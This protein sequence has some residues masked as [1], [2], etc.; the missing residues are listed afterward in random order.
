MGRMRKTSTATSEI[1]IEMLFD[2]VTLS[3]VQHLIN[4]LRNAGRRQARMLGVTPDDIVKYKL[5]THPLKDVDIQRAKDALKND[6]FFQTHKIWVAAMEKLLKMGVRAE[7][8]SPEDTRQTPGQSI[9]PRRICRH[10]HAVD[11]HGIGDDPLP[12]LQ[13][14]RQSSGDADTDDATCPGGQPVKRRFQAKMI[15]A[16]DNDLDVAAGDDASFTLQ[17][18]GGKDHHMPWAT[19]RTLLRRRL[20]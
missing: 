18:G 3:V 8:Q 4:K 5:P 7:Q 12:D 11:M 9:G 14:R 13:S 15:A 6:P 1:E 19:R 10:R 16:A 17:S 20:R 2:F